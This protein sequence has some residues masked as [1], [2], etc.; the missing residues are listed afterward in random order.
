MDGW[1][2]LPVLTAN[3]VPA[4]LGGVFGAAETIR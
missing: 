1:T 2:W 3:L 4:Q